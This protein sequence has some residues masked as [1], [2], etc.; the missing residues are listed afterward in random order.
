MR[1]KNF[2]LIELLVVIAIIAILASML[3]PALSQARERARSTSCQSNQKQSMQFMLLYASDYNGWLYL[4]NFDTWGWGVAYNVY[5]W[6]HSAPE[7]LYPG[8]WSGYLRYLK[9]TSNT[10]LFQCPRVT[11]WAGGTQTFGVRSYGVGAGVSS[12]WTM[13]ARVR[14]NRLTKS[15]SV[16]YILS[17][18]ISRNSLTS[19]YNQYFMWRTPTNWDSTGYPYLVHLGNNNFTFADGHVESWNHAKLGKEPL[20]HYAADFHFYKY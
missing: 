5:E 4:N 17:D 12:D 18:T 16:T 13:G 8:T 20:N 7:W 15:P 11:R 9:Y 1:K 14:I 19:P 2:T 6:A 10:A 3:L